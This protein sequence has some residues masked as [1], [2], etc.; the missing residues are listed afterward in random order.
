MQFTASQRGF[1][2]VA[3][4]HRAFGLA[5]SDHRVQLIDEQDDLPF[6][7]GEVVEHSLQPL[8]KLAAKFGARDE[9]AHVER[10]DALVLQAFGNLTVDDSLRE[11]FDDRGL[12]HA[13]LADQHRIIFRSA[14]QNLDRATNLIVATDHGIELAGSGSRG[15]IDRVLL[16]RLTGLLR[17]G[18]G[19]LLAAAHV[20]DGLFNRATN[21]TGVFQCLGQPAI[22]ERGEHE[23]FAGYVLIAPLL[24]ELVGDVEYAVQ[25]V[26]DVHISGRA[27]DLRQPVEL[28]TEFRPQLVDVDAGLQ[29][30]RPHGC[31]L[32]VQ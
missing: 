7:L 19:N 12:A 21:R 25:L 24:G 15:E 11:A 16:E 10:K 28:S 8:F 17:V 2:H 13:R 14:L 23:E 32:A 1:E 22:F 27:L 18:V 4:V 20:L 6:L 30:Q 26:R 5:G 31:A 9:R 29:Q 3:S